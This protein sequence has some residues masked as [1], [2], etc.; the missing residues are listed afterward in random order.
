MIEIKKEITSNVK[1]KGVDCRVDYEEENNKQEIF[2]HGDAKCDHCC[3]MEDCEC[4]NHVKLPI[5]K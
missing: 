5:K 1:I 2:C 4:H 3:G